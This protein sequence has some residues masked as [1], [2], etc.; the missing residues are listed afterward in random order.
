[1]RRCIRTAFAVWG[2]FSVAVV[3]GCEDGIAPHPMGRIEVTVTTSGA[4]LDPDGYT[5]GLDSAAAQAPVSIDGGSTTFSDVPLGQHTVWITDLA[6]N[7]TVAG[8]TVV[9]VTVGSRGTAQIAF[10]VTC[11]AFGAVR[12]TAATSG[13]DLDPDGYTIMVDGGV[14]SQ[15]LPA[16]GGAATFAQQ[17]PGMHTVEINGIAANCAVS[18][19]TSQT[20]AVASGA[21]T[22]IAYA[23]SC[24]AFGA[25]LVTATTSGADLDPDGYTVQVDGQAGQVLPTNGGAATFSQVAPGPRVVTLGGVRANCT[26]LGSSQVTV[27]V[28]SGATAAVEFAITCVQIMPTGSAIAFVRNSGGNRE[29][30]LVTGGSLPLNLTNNAAAD[31]P[32]VWSPDGTKIAFVSDRDGNSE[33]YVMN[34]DGSGQLNLTNNAAA[35]SSPAW[36]PDGSRIAFVS[37]RDGNAEV[38]VMNADGTG[39]VDLSNHPAADGSPAWA[40]D[41]LALAF[42][43][44]RDG[45][46]E[47]YLM[48]ADG[49]QP[50]NLS[51]NAAAD[52]DPVWSPDGSRIAFGSD[53]DGNAEIYLMNP[54]GTGQ[55][56]LTNS[57]AADGSPAWSPDGRRIVFA[58]GGVAVINADGT[59]FA[60]LITNTSCGTNGCLSRTSSGPVWSPDRS[61]IAFQWVSTQRICRRPRCFLAYR[62]GISVMN[63]DGSVTVALVDDPVS[64]SGSPAWRPR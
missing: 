46:Q 8:Q 38:Y 44:D 9:T 19:Q 39:A 28:P 20:V 59:G 5:I 6:A 33:I 60:R 54:D 1:M 30:F 47:I 11:V 32:P 16:N 58:S 64:G 57:P 51:N 27:T 62:S 7:C 15:A 45:N 10:A 41:G 37:D 18:G 40:P 13:A 21:T 29:V 34:P 53:R 26:V 35:E 43:S 36:S 52:V 49:S 17:L 23:V 12:V 48:N 31:G 42:V 56:N 63:P 61:K 14:A 4:D 24:A 25:V 55:V 3:S 2:F 50:A 22:E